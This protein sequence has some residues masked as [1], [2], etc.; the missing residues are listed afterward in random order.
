MIGLWP[1][2]Q[3]NLV[4]K[5]SW[6]CAGVQLCSGIA[7]DESTE[8]TIDRLNDESKD[9]L[10]LLAVKVDMTNFVVLYSSCS[11]LKFVLQKHF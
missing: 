4:L 5:I 1:R 11:N 9:A 2:E 8:N 10:A 6:G 3:F 7:W